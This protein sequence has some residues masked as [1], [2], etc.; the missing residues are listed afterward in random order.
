MKRIAAG[1]LTITAC[2]GDDVA[3]QT[4]VYD[5]RHPSAELDV[6]ARAGSTDAP[7]VVYLHGGAWRVGSRES[8]QATAERLAR[9]GYVVANVDYRLVPDGVF[10]LAVQDA[11]CALA[12][13]RAHAGE[14]GVDP[15]RIA[16]MGHSAGAH[17]VAMVGVAA[18][19][20]ELQDAGCPSGLT[21]APAAVVSVAGPMDLRVIGGSAVDEFVG[22]T[23]GVDPERFARASPI[24]Q[25]GADEPRF[26]F[27]HST[28]DLI[29]DLSQSERMLATLRAAG[30]DAA[31]LQLE[32]GG[33]I[34]GDGAGL[35]LESYELA[36]DTPEAWL[37]ILDF[38]GQT[39]GRP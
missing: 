19:V 27:V 37:A 14:L 34:V 8:D 18:D 5:D 28:H 17:L 35:G 3:M 20:A 39:I 21:A 11:A 32:G 15:Q 12:F 7:A 30:N 25:V 33:H 38:L 4:Y 1:L 31:L 9:A 13:V 36:T 22:A 2:A 23:R 24:A 26:L 29:V 16:V 10:P 6:H